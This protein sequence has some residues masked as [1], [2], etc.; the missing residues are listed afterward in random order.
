M[1]ILDVSHVNTGYGK[2][3]ILFDVSLAIPKGEITLIMGPNGSGKSTLF[4][5]IYGL[6]SLWDNRGSLYFD[7]ENITNAPTHT[8]L[9]NGIMYIP[10]KNELFESLS[11]EENLLFS[12]LHKNKNS[13]KKSQ[14]TEVYKLIPL[15]SSKKKQLAED[16]SGGERKLLTLGMVIMNTPKLLLYDEPLAGVST[17]NTP[18]ICDVFEK[19]QKIGTTIV[20]IEHRIKEIHLLV[21]KI[22][23]MKLGMLSNEEFTSIDDIKNFMI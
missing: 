12:V 3:Q 10:Q 18:I 8:L 11:V 13:I 21:T 16:L 22:V 7:G 9:K 17:D 1:N 2:K 6:V 20:L 15:L 14:L 23:G 19:I 5:T 4:K